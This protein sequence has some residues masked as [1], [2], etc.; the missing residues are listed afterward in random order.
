MAGPFFSEATLDDLMRV[1]VEEILEKGEDT[2]PSKGKAREINGVLLELRNPRARLSGTETRGKPFSCLGELCWYLAKSDELAFIEYY[3]SEYEKYADGDK[4]FCGYGPRFFDWNGI[5]QVANIVALLKEKRPSRQA[6]I[7]L[8]DARDI[9]EKHNH[10]PCTC[11]LQFMIRRDQL[12]MFVNMRSNDAYRGLPHDIFAFTMLQEITAREL[13]VEIGTYKHSVGSLH[14]YEE[15]I[16]SAKQFMSEGWQST[17]EAMPAMP[18]GDPQPNINLALELEASIRVDGVCNAANLKKL[19]PYWADLVRLLQVY[20]H[21]KHSD[22]QTADAIRAIRQ[23]M[24]SPIYSPFIDNVLAK[25][26]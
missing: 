16:E 25:L 15:N 7:Q 9:I 13:G 18:A 2:E 1:V 26:A 8:F 12:L 23:D 4:I 19:D 21:K 24:N 14:L 5:D 11:T 3:I 17:K 10:V 20:R 6:V 22:S